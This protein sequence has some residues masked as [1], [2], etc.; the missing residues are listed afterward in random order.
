MKREVHAECH[1][2]K[3]SEGSR[4]REIYACRY[5]K[6]RQN[7]HHRSIQCHR[8]A[9]RPWVDLVVFRILRKLRAGHHQCH[10]IWHSTIKYGLMPRAGFEFGTT[11]NIRPHCLGCVIGVFFL[12]FSTAVFNSLMCISSGIFGSTCTLLCSC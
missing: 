12:I 2:E 5:A 4:K 1:H 10:E 7:L 6:F 8:V 9:L 3:G 11:R